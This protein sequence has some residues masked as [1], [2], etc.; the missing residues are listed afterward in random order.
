MTYFLKSQSMKKLLCNLPRFVLWIAFLLIIESY[1]TLQAQTSSSN[2]S[3]KAISGKIVDETDLPIAGAT[4]QVKGSTKGAISDIDGLFTISSEPGSILIFSFLGYQSIEYKIDKVPQT[5]KLLPKVDELDEVT[6]VGFAKQ[7][8][9]SVIGA[10]STLKPERL[11][12]PTSNLTQALGGNVAGIISYQLSGEPGNDNVEFFIRGVTTFGYSKSPLILIDNIESSTTDLSRLSA[13]DIAAFSIMKD[14]TATAIYGAR[15]ANGVILITTKQGK[16]GK[17]K[18]SA[19]VE[20][21]LSAPTKRIDMVDPISYMKYHNEAVL[22]RNPL[23]VRPHTDEKIASTIAGKNP[24]VYPAVD[25]YNELFNDNVFNSRA[26]INM[27]GGSETARYYVSLGISDDNGIMKVDKRNNYNSNIDLKKIYVRSN[28]DIDVTKTTTFSVKFSGNFDD[29]TGPIVSGNDLY[30]RAMATSPVLFPKYYMPDENHTSTSHILFGNAGDGNYINPYA[31]MIR[32]YKQYTNSV[33]SAQAELNQKLDFITPGLSIKVFA[34]TTRNSYSGQQRSTSPFYYSISYYD[35]LTDTYTLRE[36]N[37]N[38]GREDLDYTAEGNQVSSSYYYEASLNYN[39]TFR[40]K[41][42]ITGLLVGVLRENK[43]GGAS[44][45]QTSLPARNIGLSGRFTYAYDGRYFAEANFGYNGSERFAKNERFGFFPSIGAGWMISEEKFWNQDLKNIINK[46]KLKGTYGLVGND[47][48]GAWNDRFFYM[49][50]V[51]LNGSG[52]NFSW[53]QD[54]ERNVGTIDMIR[55]RNDKIKWEIAQKMNLGLEV[56]LFN[57]FDIQFDYFTEYRKNIFGERQTIP[58]EMGFS[59]P[60]YANKGEASSHGFE[61]QVDAN[62]AFNKNFWLGVRGNFT[63]ATGKYEHVEEPYRPYPWLSHIGKRINQTYGLIAERLFIDEEDIANSPV[64]TYGEYMPGDIK[65]KDVNN[66]GIINDEDIVP[67]G[68]SSSPEI[69]YGFGVSMGYKNFDI[70]CFFQGAARSSFF[71]N[72]KA[73][74]PFMQMDFGGNNLNGMMQAYADDYWSESN[75]NIYAT[76]PRLSTTD[77]ANNN[78]N[79]TWWLRDGSYLRLK[80][81]EIGYTLPKR[82]T[83]HL[84]MSNLRIYAS[85]LNLFAWNRFKL[86]DVE[87]GNDGMQYPIQAVYNFGINLSF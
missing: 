5:I 72:S 30:R 49:S 54:F 3:S 26:N 10:I 18:I 25:W 44:S 39:R 46:L 19:R 57:I 35:K 76:F 83:S 52:A 48:I 65:Y 11:K 85:G 28:I 31:E 23:A 60:L 51:N 66:D 13:D 12:I 20:G 53:G 8:K 21:S 22:T 2:N 80:S 27:S 82:L 45:I 16:P 1:V 71:I 64:Q 36:L 14:A 77:I 73:T 15:G 55:Y 43:S 42:N 67:I 56:G 47:N 38:G 17:V 33:I 59:A 75:R 34:S 69:V 74:N 7:K 87:Q 6:V 9:E 79:S 61:V 63:Y 58:Y 41:H 84:G 40:E 68:I 78:R 81:V 24:Y 29:Y 50:E 86:W 37:P 4:V 32:G 62:H 70:S